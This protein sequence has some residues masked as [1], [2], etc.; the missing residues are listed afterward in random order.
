VF[1]THMEIRKT[2]YSKFGRDWKVCNLCP[3]DAEDLEVFSN[4]VLSLL[5]L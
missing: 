4:K 1:H 2:Q 5:K 3:T